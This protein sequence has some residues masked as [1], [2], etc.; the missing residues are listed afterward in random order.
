[1]Q[2]SEKGIHD[3]VTADSRYRITDRLYKWCQSEDSVSS[4]LAAD[5]KLAPGDAWQKLFHGHHFSSGEQDYIR[6]VGKARIS[7]EEM[8]RA[9]LCG[10]WGSNEPSDL[11]LRVSF[12][13]KR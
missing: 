6:N 4:L 11:F 2:G 5:P 3:E 13:N 10:K 1:M 7:D 9:R 12:L 8:R